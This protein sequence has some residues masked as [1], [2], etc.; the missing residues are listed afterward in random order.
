MS[1]DRTELARDKL[2]KIV[3]LFPNDPAAAKAKQLLDQIGG[4]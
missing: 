4:P 1:N 2:Q 3:E